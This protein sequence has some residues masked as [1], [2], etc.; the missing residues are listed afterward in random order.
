MGCTN[1]CW[2]GNL[3]YYQHLVS[4]IKTK[5]YRFP[6]QIIIIELNPLLSASGGLALSVSTSHAVDRGFAPQ[7]DHNKDHHK[8]VHTSFPVK[9]VTSQ[10]THSDLIERSQY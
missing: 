3:S 7:S 9:N 2:F 4:E 5:F 1:L 8:M 6:S 10:L